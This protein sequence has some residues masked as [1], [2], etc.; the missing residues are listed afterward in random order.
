MPFLHATVSNIPMRDSKQLILTRGL[1][2]TVENMATI[3]VH[4]KQIIQAPYLP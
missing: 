4:A 3:R 2:Q 1:V